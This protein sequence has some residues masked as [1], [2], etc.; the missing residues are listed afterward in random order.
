EGAFTMAAAAEVQLIGGARS[1]NVFWIS[2][3]ASSIG[4]GAKMV[5]N[6]IAHPGAVSLGVG[7]TLDG[8]MLSTSGA[9]TMNAGTVTKPTETSTVQV[10]CI[11]ECVNED[12]FGS[13]TA[14]ANF[15]LF[16]GVG[17]VSNTGISGVIGDIGTNAGALSI[18]GTSIVIGDFHNANATTAQAKTELTQLHANLLAEPATNTTHTPTFGSGE[19]LSPGVYSIAAAGSVAGELTLNGDEDDIFIFKFGGAFTTGAAS[20]IIL[21][22]GVQS[23]NVFWIANGAISMGAFTF[24][25]G[26]TIANGANSMGANGF[27]EGRM[28]ATVGA[29]NFYTA[30]TYIYNDLN[31]VCDDCLDPVYSDSDEDGV[32]DPCDNCPEIYNPYQEDCD[33]DGIGDACE[34]CD[35]F[36]SGGQIGFGDIAIC[37]AIFYMGYSGVDGPTIENCVLPS[38]GSGCIEYIWLAST[39]SS[40]WP[41]STVIDIEAGNDPHWNLIA[42]A[43]SEDHSPGVISQTTYFLRCARRVGCVPYMGEGNMVTINCATLGEHNIGGR[44]WHD[45]NDDGFRDA[46]EYGIQNVWVSLTDAANV[47]IKD[48]VGNDVSVQSDGSGYY[49]FGN[50][51]PGTYKIKF[52]N[53]GGYITAY[54]DQGGN[55]DLDSDMDNSG[56]TAPFVY[57]GG[58]ITNMDAGFVT[59]ANAAGRSSSILDLIAVKQVKTVDLLWANN[60]SFRNDHFVIERSAD[61]EN[62]VELTEVAD[63]GSNDERAWNYEGVD[64]NPMIGNNFYRVKVVFRDGAFDYTNTKLVEFYSTPDFALFPNPATSKV[65]LN[66][67]RYV[68]KDVTIS[69]QDNLGRNQIVNTFSN[70]EDTLVE[71]D[72]SALRNGAYHVYVSTKDGLHKVKKMIV[73]KTY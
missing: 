70:L 55:D 24:M 35:N 12:Y 72:I 32:D 51:A 15:T 6:L 62:F 16:S 43:N 7:C 37:P 39:T 68:G 36:T 59:V 11:S 71:V 1:S 10:S 31:I 5:G 34:E 25:K 20:K 42:G 17:A 8:R 54:T 58:T 65:Y 53:P 50:V 27:I 14:L 21:T 18:W 22:G 41:T 56:S 52:G 13:N 69:I 30:T 26:T 67:E 38:G 61:G 63:Y 60:T 2:E 73:M 3:G 57:S 40:A 45:E 49:V 66:L 4:A 23:C 47:V 48:A 46:G 9:V 28:Y 19:T 33:G 29:V 44:V 64:T